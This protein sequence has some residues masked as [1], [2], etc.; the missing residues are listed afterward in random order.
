M[1]IDSAL[2]LAKRLKRER[3]ARDL[4]LVKRNRSLP[5]N[6]GGYFERMAG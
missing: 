3:Q 1:S 2:A 4:P 6:G 5:F